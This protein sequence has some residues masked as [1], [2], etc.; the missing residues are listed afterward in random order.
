MSEATT[1][2]FVILMADLVAAGL[3]A[4]AKH[5]WNKKP[6]IKRK[7]KKVKKSKRKLAPVISIEDK[8]GAS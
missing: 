5:F 2:F 4:T 6:K 1:W 8:K 7:K 3:I